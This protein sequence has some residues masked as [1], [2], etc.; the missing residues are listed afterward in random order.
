MEAAS[1]M[2]QA[3]GAE[4]REAKL[5][6]AERMRIDDHYKVRRRGSNHKGMGTLSQW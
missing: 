2:E 3:S 4:E 6:E 5:V 1:E